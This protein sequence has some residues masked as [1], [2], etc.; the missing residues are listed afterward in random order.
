MT[1]A[2]ILALL[3]IP[4]TA[5]ITSLAIFPVHVLGKRLQWQD[6]SID[7]WREMGVL[8]PGERVPGISFLFGLTV[9]PG[10]AGTDL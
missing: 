4:I 3:S 9:L 7:R 8:C 6:K 2:F 1:L 10:Q 5:T